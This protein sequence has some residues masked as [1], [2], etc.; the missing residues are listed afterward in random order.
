MANQIHS[1]KFD[2]DTIAGLAKRIAQA[3]ADY[4]DAKAEA[5]AASR[6]A[7]SKSVDLSNLKIEFTRAVKLVGLDTTVLQLKD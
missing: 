4:L 3:E 5:E 2:A 1:S 6:F 7:N